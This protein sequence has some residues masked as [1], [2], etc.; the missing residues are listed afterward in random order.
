M[1]PGFSFE[2]ELAQRAGVRVV[3]A[4]SAA[5]AD[6]PRAAPTVVLRIESAGQRSE[7]SA[8]LAVLAT[9]DH[10]GI[11]R[12]VGHGC[13]PGGATWVAREWIDGQDLLAWSQG[14]PSEEIG[15]AVARLT[16]ALEHLHARGFVHGDLKP[17]N[18]IVAS[19]GRVVLC[20]FGLARA[21]GERAD[22]AGVSGT[23]YSIAPELLLGAPP[24]PTA[25]LFALGAML[26]RLLAR[27][28][29]SAREFYASFPRSS[30]LDAAGSRPEELPVW[31][32]DLVVALTSR[33]PARRTKSARL[34]GRLLAARLGG[35][36]VFGDA[37]V[38]L[39]WPVGFGRE[40]WLV[41]W[42]A[43]IVRADASQ[44][45]WVRVP[46]AEDPRPFWEH[47]RLFASLRGRPSARLDL[48]RELAS[49]PD[50]A[51]LD[52]WAAERA[53]DAQGGAWLVACATHVD[54]WCARA[55]ATLARALSVKGVPAQ[56][57]VV[58]ASP[59]PSSESES[60]AA[61][62]A[63]VPPA[64]DVRALPGVSAE[65]LRRFLAQ[66]FA[67]EERE[68]LEDFARALLAA[69]RGSA[70]RL[71]ALLSAAARRGLLL[72]GEDKLRLR[73]GDAAS[74]VPREDE[75]PRELVA[76]LSPLA[77]EALAALAL[78]GRRATSDEIVCALGAD[79]QAVG[80]ALGEL[81]R[82]RAASPRS[83][84]L[85]GHP[86]TRPLARA[87]RALVRPD[88]AS[89]GALRAELETLRGQGRAE[90]ALAVL[91]R[92]L[93]AA[94]LLGIEAGALP[95]AHALERA[96]TWC[97]L[98]RPD[99]ARGALEGLGQPA[100]ASVAAEVERIQ[101]VIARLQHDTDRAL[102]HLDRARALDPSLAPTVLV[103]R[104]HL[105]HSLGRDREAIELVEA[106]GLDEETRTGR[107]TPRAADYA[108][109]LAAMSAF[110]LGRVD[111]ARAATSALAVEAARAEDPG[112]EA[113]RRLNL[114]T[115]ERRA[116]S[117][118]RAR[119]ELERS[120][121]LYAAAG[122][123]Q[124][125]AHARETLG[126][127]LRELGEPGASE[128]LL[129]QSME[130][131]ERL[132]DREGAVT[133][134]AM[135]GLTLAERGALQ[136]AV[137]TLRECLGSMGPARR[138]R[139]GA[140]LAAKAEELEARIGRRATP[141]VAEAGDEADPRVFLA[142]GRAARLRGEA[143]SARAFF[144][145]AERLATSLSLRRIV[146]EA[147]WLSARLT[148]TA[149]EGEAAEGGELLVQDAALL[150]LL[151]RTGER[152][153]APRLATLAE[154]L[155][156]AGR[157]DRAA[158]A[159]FALAARIAEPHEAARAATR[160]AELLAA[161]GAGLTREESEALRRHLLGE[162]DPWPGD[163]SPRPQPDE[164]DEELA[165]QITALIDVQRR[166]VQEEDLETLLG[167]IVETAMSLTGAERGFFV[168]EAHGQL[169]F[170]T[171]RDSARG[172]IP[173][174]E[175]EVSRSVVQAAL[176]RMQPMRLSNAA[177]DPLLG[178]ATSVVSLELRSILCVP[179]DIGRGLRGALYI[180]HRL[181]TGAFD[182]RAERW[183]TLFANHAALAI[184][185]LDRVAEIRRLNQA[186]EKRV[187]EQASD[188]ERARAAL[189]QASAI[190]AT[191]LVGSSPAIRAVRDLLARAASAALPVLITGPSGTG[192]ELA[193]RSLH[194]LSA[195]RDGP[196]VSE[197][198]A[199]L[200][201]S[202]IESELFGWTKGAFTGA[203]R[204]RAGLF[205]QASGGTLFLDEIGELPIELQAKLLRVLETHEVRRLGSSEAT[206]IDVRLVAATNRDLESETRAG[207]FREDLFYRL[208]GL[209]VVMPSLAERAEDVPVLIE[210]FLQSEE[211]RT[212]TK[213][214]VSKAV[215]ARLASRAWP[216]NVRE[217]RNE[218]AR[219][220]VLSPGDL[221]D[222]ALVRDASAPRA[223]S[224]SGEILPLVEL[225]RRAIL[226][227]VEKTGGDKRKAADL[228]GISRAKVY[229][230]LKE[231]RGGEEAGPGDAGTKLEEP[232]PGR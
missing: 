130:T 127:L 120:A 86:A 142:R 15:R 202:L 163:L 203:D 185:Q 13:L 30:F 174:P 200:P 197:S 82:V 225:E 77:R 216:G 196:F 131:R 83:S 227:A 7:E 40:T 20:D 206:H 100:P 95:G 125:L 224:S 215:Q 67:P 114:A 155:A 148:G 35:E 116:G 101:A 3:R 139:F 25:D 150:A 183:V 132:G 229:Q 195:R 80:Q 6:A 10:P 78:A 137:A 213:R 232:G 175:L 50:S 115:I 22:G 49:I 201:A 113:A 18:V 92:T 177:D 63:D 117:L 87:L 128:P 48:D 152:F 157:D 31:A 147:R 192:K 181:R 46:S 104:I 193:A 219:L 231:W 211:A 165:M 109:S 218:V 190:E 207:R 71:G 16:P 66:N 118:A 19:D 43:E 70:T 59:P 54:A 69:A 212:G 169:A 182:E 2:A 23:F 164:S 198:C 60:G 210:H 90:L 47:L 38:E 39:A 161:C 107:M 62:E 26:F 133:A 171:A 42:L 61:E 129:V 41:A 99:R 36:V 162:P 153:D 58:S 214:R 11:A 230:R 106:S 146:V 124:G 223:E 184:Q 143:P 208:D 151:G 102:A 121:A 68:R 160:A 81:L 33:E 21:S 179:V 76:V 52:A 126:G 84:S 172:D 122:L 226:A 79:P 97:A 64:W 149:R 138:R 221:D 166:L 12:L 140:L 93:E 205:E 4:R 178:H 191:G 111:E 112:R 228:L 194:A 209:R 65:S 135:L 187:V 217:L 222:P 96:L 32:R 159:Y 37:A 29:R 51:A 156:R 154:E 89:L 27:P 220:C 136:A 55:L 94:S 28:Q 189:R 45:S 167:T 145:R 57:A 105:L 134:R 188:L 199:A 75:L 56:L 170:D 88:P 53:R 8:E 144:E 5:P 24:A 141:S 103:D 91:D 176:E 180:D 1:P 74:L 108:R 34:V 168:L 123:A 119:A 72:G 44:P 73:P 158:R 98:A 186:L 9:V 14:R 110:R 204:E 17:E 173:A 85:E